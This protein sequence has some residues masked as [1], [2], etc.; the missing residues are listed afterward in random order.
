MDEERL[1]ERDG[2]HKNRGFL[3]EACWGGEGKGRGK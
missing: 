1:R 3:Q 2:V